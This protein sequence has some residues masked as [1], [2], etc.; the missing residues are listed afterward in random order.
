MGASRSLDMDSRFDNVDSRANNADSRARLKPEKRQTQRDQSA[1][2]WSVGWPFGLTIR[3]STRQ[4]AETTE[5]P[6]RR[7]HLGRPRGR[8]HDLSLKAL[9]RGE[10]DPYA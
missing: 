7:D 1:S 3:P 2:G 6:L 10:A 4:D 5:G 8:D 9:A